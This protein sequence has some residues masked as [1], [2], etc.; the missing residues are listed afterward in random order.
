M[1]I[2]IIGATGWLGH[3]LG[4]GL[5]R[6]GVV[7]PDQMVLANRSGR[8]D[9]YDGQAVRWTRDLSELVALSDLIVVSVRPQDWHGLHLTAAGKPVLSFLA[10]TPSQV[11]ASCGGRILRAMPNAAAEI[12]QSYSPFWAAPDATPDDMAMVRLI[13]SAIGDT[14]QV[15]DETHLD[16]M[17][18]LPGSGAAY[19]ALMAV[20]M[21]DFMT[22]HGVDQKIAW[23]AT[24][25]T[26]C[27]GTDLLRG[28]MDQAP[29][30]LSAYLDYRGITA[31]GLEA[32]QDAGF[33]A[34]I[35]TALDAALA[36]TRAMAADHPP[37][38]HDITGDA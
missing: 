15:Q 14:D 25:A 5:I 2:G 34:A 8:Q 27:G 6:Q 28:K 33:S 35:G 11:L 7:R 38:G 26:L 36:K 1:Q 20:A 12:G 17:G 10:A 32:A 23:R 30:M 24:E 18:A 37:A 21:A 29:A 16:L 4:Q 31:A 13:L 9:G 19:P 3:A 22:R